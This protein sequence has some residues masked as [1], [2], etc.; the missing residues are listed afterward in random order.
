MSE[1][2]T[3][4]AALR[5]KWCGTYG[6]ARCPAHDDGSPSLSIKDGT[7]TE[8]LLHC[9][10]GCRFQDIAD[11]L[12]R[13]DLMPGREAGDGPRPARR[14]EP[15]PVDPDPEEERKE[16]KR[17]RILATWQAGEPV[18]VDRA[19]RYLQARGLAI[20]NLPPTLRQGF[21]K[22]EITGPDLPCLIAAIA[23]EKP[24]VTAIQRIFLTDDWSSKAPLGVPKQTLGPM[25]S[26][27]VRLA[28]PGEVLG[29]A[30]GIET[31]LAA[32]QL[33]GIPTWAALMAG[34]LEKIWIPPRVKRLVIFA[35]NDKTG[36]EHAVAARQAHAETGRTIEVKAPDREK[37]DWA[38][39]A[40]A[41][42][43]ERGEVKA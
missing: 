26:G 18:T 30:E 13:M 4:T 2:Q 43:K 17:R 10:A 40:L 23:G 16:R 25:G 6:M 11:A 22:N 27:A 15:R 33:H 24:N 31:A 20:D 41:M 39:V 12:R 7:A 21:S 28:L 38:D 34:R 36:L 32:M 42:A 19:G 1:A 8:L 9:F 29:I 14:L 35:D 37:W 5:G 3:I